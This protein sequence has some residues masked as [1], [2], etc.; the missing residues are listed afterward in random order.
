MFYW[1]SRFMLVVPL[2]TEY[3]GP[4]DE[5][6]DQ[7]PGLQLHLIH[8]IKAGFKWHRSNLIKIENA[9]K[10]LPE[11]ILV[12]LVTMGGPSMTLVTLVRMGAPW[13]TLV[14][15]VREG[16]PAITLVTLVREGSASITLVTLVTMGSEWITLVTLVTSGTK[17]WKKDSSY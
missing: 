5:I 16:R 9:K 6:T 11:T 8:G 7:S 17:K 14:T 1:P 2:L 4:E 10:H 15:L 3:W 12:T 13:M